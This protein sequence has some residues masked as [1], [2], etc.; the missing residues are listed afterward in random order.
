[1]SATL[2]LCIKAKMCWVLYTSISEFLFSCYFW[3][4][5]ILHD[6]IRFSRSRKKHHSWCSSTHSLYSRGKYN[7]VT[8]PFRTH[9]S[10][11]KYYYNTFASFCCPVGLKLLAHCA[12]QTWG[13]TCVRVSAPLSTMSLSHRHKKKNQPMVFTRFWHFPSDNVTTLRIAPTYGN[14]SSSRLSTLPPLL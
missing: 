8:S 12:S 3:P 4:F 14:P 6:A 2:R 11:T 1:M 13:Q 5:P 7:R 10:R 9:I